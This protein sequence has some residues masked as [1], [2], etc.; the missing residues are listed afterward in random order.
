MSPPS[1]CKDCETVRLSVS[2]TGEV[3]IERGQW[4]VIHQKWDYRR[5]P[6]KTKAQNAAAFIAAMAP[7]RPLGVKAI[8]GNEAC[9]ATT[10]DA[11]GGVALRW[12]DGLRDDRLTVSFACAPYAG[13]TWERHVRDA[14]ALLKLSRPIF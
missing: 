4:D 3:L 8:S 1:A 9:T 10:G 12:V 14:A 2:P 6:T 5:T 13:S 11:G 7:D